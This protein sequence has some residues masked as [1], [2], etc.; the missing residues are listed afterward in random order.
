MSLTE[1]SGW[2]TRILIYQPF[3]DAYLRVLNGANQPDLAVV[4][5]QAIGVPDGY[6]AER[7]VTQRSGLAAAV[8]RRNPVDLRR[9][10]LLVRPT[11]TLA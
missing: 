4:P 11:A 9:L 3:L 2:T 7:E 6:R 5:A 8:R 1:V 10:Q